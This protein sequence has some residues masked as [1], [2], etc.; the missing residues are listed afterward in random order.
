MRKWVSLS[1]FCLLVLAALVFLLPDLRGWTPSDLTDPTAR[2][3]PTARDGPAFS[4]NDCLPGSVSPHELPDTKDGAG[5]VTMTV[6]TCRSKSSV[7]TFGMIWL[8]LSG[9]YL[10]VHMRRAKASKTK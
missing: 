10:V 2:V 5:S 8:I 4:V 1:G 3:V 6:L 9:S 7:F